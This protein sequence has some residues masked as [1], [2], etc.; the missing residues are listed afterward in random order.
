[1]SGLRTPTRYSTNVA[2]LAKSAEKNWTLKATYVEIYNEQLRDLL[3]P[4]H[5]PLHERGAV[6]IRED[7]KGHILLTGLHQVEINSVEDLMAALNF[8]SMI[9][10]TDSTAINAKSSRS[11][12]VFSL[13]LIQRKSKLQTAQGAEKRLS[14]PLEA[15]TGADTLVTIDSKLHFVDLAGSERLKNTGAQGERAKE[16]ISINAGL[17]SLGKVISQLSSRQAGSHVSYRDSKLTRLLQDSLGGNAITYMIACV[18][19]AE[20]HLSETLNTVQYA[21]R[22]RAI[23]SKPRI[24]QISDNEADKQALIDRLK[25]EVAFLREQIRSTERGGDRRNLTSERPERQNEREMEL[26]NQ[27]LDTQ[28]NYTSLSQRHAKLIS[29]MAKARDGEIAD[30]HAFEST[31]GDSATERLKRSNSFAEAVEQ[32]VLEYEKTIQS[33]EQSLSSTRSSLS[34]TETTLLEKE[35]KCAYVETVNQQLQSRLQKLMDRETSTENYLHDL[36]AKL[37]GHTSGEEKN[38]AIVM[39]LRKEIARVRENEASCEDY[40]STLEERLAEADQDA[41]LMQREIDRLEHVVERQRS[42]GKLDNLLYELDHIQQDGKGSEAGA[43]PVA[44]NGKRSFNDHSRHQ[45]L[46]SRRSHKDVI[47]EE[48]D[49]QHS[50]RAHRSATEGPIDNGE[51]IEGDFAVQKSLETPVNN[52]YSPQSPA[53]SKFVEDKLENVTQEL[54]DLRVEHE[55]TVNEFD[56]LQA[57]Y[58]EALRTLAA[59]QDAVDEARHPNPRDSIL[60]A[61]TPIDTR[62][63]S[64]LSDARVDELKDGGQFSSS[65]SLSS[66]LSSAGELPSTLEI[67]DAEVVNKKS[68]S[69][70]VAKTIA[71]D[72]TI[73]TEVESLRKLAE[74]KEQAQRL[75]AEKYAELEEKHM[76]ALDVVEELKAEVSKAKMNE[77]QS[78]RATTPVIRRKSSQNV[79]IC[80]E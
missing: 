62:P 58:D 79:M 27:L 14:V 24:Q 53:Q 20:F 18:T 35:T 7:T 38:A 55:G 25:A 40:I 64:F 68:E 77:A 49:D 50:E 37:D 48:E 8:G 32:V 19:P 17:A 41:E 11:H 42:L 10:Q 69:V 65:R 36:E 4:E 6:T 12:A 73:A 33:L 9:R 22:A 67:S 46:A 60:S 39:E 16:G 31:L 57:K 45:S 28:E 2:A 15:M 43:E 72:E 5:T 80:E 1:M 47:P 44:V 52:H 76:D 51:P 21:Q 75:L 13:N 23:Q 71:N 66:E 34:N 78:P 29:E 70:E 3:V 26:Q 56:L 30:N 54:L 74:E 63:T 61:S 59:L